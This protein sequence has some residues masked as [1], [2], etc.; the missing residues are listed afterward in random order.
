VLPLVLGHFAERLAD[1]DWIIYD[2]GRHYG[3]AFDRGVFRD[4]GLDEAHLRQGG[5]A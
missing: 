3:V 2:A 1:Q 5:G 4:V